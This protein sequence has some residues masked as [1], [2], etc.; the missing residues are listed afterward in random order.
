M[1]VT[2]R[3]DIY[4]GEVKEA[5][6]QIWTG[7]HRLLM[8]QTE[9]HALD[10]GNTLVPTDKFGYDQHTPAEVGACVF[11]TANALKAVLDAGHKTNLAKLL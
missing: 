8:L 7:L 9:W 2:T 6:K 1:A 11:D 10:Y 5:V 3:D 4:V